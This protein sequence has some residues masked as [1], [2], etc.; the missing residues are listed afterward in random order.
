MKWLE[1]QNIESQTIDVLAHI[2]PSLSYEENIK[3]MKRQLGLGGGRSRQPAVRGLTAAECDVAIGNFEAG[4]NHEVTRDACKCGH[5]EACEKLERVRRAKA[6]MKPKPAPKPD[7]TLKIIDRRYYLCRGKSEPVEITEREA[8]EVVRKTV[9]KD[10]AGK[11]V[12]D[13][14]LGE[15]AKQHGFHG[16]WVESAYYKVKPSRSIESIEKDIKK[17]EEK[18]YKR[19][20]DSRAQGGSRPGGGALDRDMQ[21]IWEGKRNLKDELERAKSQ[22]PNLK[23]IEDVEQWIVKKARE[24]GS[25]NEFLCSSEYAE[26][27]PEITRIHDQVKKRKKEERKRVKEEHKRV[28]IIENPYGT[29]YVIKYLYRENAYAGGGG[30]RGGVSTFETVDKAIHEAKRSGYTIV[31][32]PKATKPVARKPAPDLPPALTAPP[33]LTADVLGTGPMGQPPMAAPK[34][35]PAARTTR[36]QPAKPTPTAVPKARKPKKTPAAKPRK[37]TKKTAKPKAKKTAAAPK[38]TAAQ[39]EHLAIQGFVMVRRGGKYVKITR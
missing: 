19:S 31:S 20:K 36:K 6:A 14:K 15:Y 22:K 13:K 17:A 38:L 39:R 34:H 23:T 9:A 5:P 1:S 11:R 21:R 29:G 8:Y 10:L 24:Y 37:T 7:V 25:R 3:S 35:K 4:F 28:S 12:S 33:E 16:G 18:A 32:K 30:M 27:Y 2:D 26:R